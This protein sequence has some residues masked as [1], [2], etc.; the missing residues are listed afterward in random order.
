MYLA[1][2]VI[3]TLK[4]RRKSQAEHVPFMGKGRTVH[5]VLVGNFKGKRP[6]RQNAMVIL[7]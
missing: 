4:S 5:Q 6:V 7:Q 3:R 1:P 2:N